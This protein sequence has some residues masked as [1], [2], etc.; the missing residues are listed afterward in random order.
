MLAEMPD[1]NHLITPFP[2]KQGKPTCAK[3][4]PPRKGLVAA[5]QAS[6]RYNGYLAGL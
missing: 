5:D 6:L 2:E 1:Y 3:A 4:W